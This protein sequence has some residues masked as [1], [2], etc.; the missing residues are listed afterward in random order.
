MRALVLLLQLISVFTNCMARINVRKLSLKLRSSS[1]FLTSFV[2]LF[3]SICALK[4]LNQGYI[5]IKCRDTFLG[6]DSQI[7][8]VPL[9][10]SN[11][12]SVLLLN[13]ISA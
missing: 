7:S 3:Y 8:W 1:F 4:I 11:T 10:H 13:N 6:F 5:A 2:Y 12:P 9:T